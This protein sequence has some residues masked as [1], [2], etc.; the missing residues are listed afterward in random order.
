MIKQ[1]TG[2]FFIILAAMLWGTIGTAT[3]LFSA[4]G[5]SSLSLIFYRS[6]V[7]ALLLFVV[8]LLKDP[9]LLKI[10]LR[11]LW[12]FI[13]SGIVSFFLFNVCYMFSIGLNSIAASAILL[14]TSPIF[15]M[16]FSVMFL[17]ERFTAQKGIALVLAF[18]GCVLVSFGGALRMSLPGL[19]LGFGSGIGYALYSIFGAVALKRYHTLTITFYTFLFASLASAFTTDFVSDV[20]LFGAKPQLLLLVILYAVWSTTLPYLL[21][22]AGLSCINATIASIISTIEPVVA[23]ILGFFVFGEQLSL[24]ALLGMALVLASIFLLNVKWLAKKKE[25]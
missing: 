23:A 7:T 16:L 10:R 5:L 24:A 13:G 21:Y 25:L 9:A 3:R 14:Y 1:R 19:A 12:M 2:L 15:V 11:D 17:H 22:T 6:C 18:G 4:A 8:L 20:A